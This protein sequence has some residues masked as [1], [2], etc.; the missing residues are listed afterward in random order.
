MQSVFLFFR[1]RMA[2]GRALFNAWYANPTLLR[3]TLRESQTAQALFCVP[4]GIMVSLITIFLHEAVT[5]AQYWA[6]ALT[7][8]GDLSAAKPTEMLRILGVPV[9]G[10]A[11]LGLILWGLKRW[12]SGDIVDPIEANA[13]YGGRMSVVDSLRLAL[14]AIVSNASGASVGMEAAYTQMGA[15]AT[16]RIGKMFQLRREDMRV[17][18]AAGAAAAIAT[19]FNAPLAGA[20]YGFELVLSTYT[21]AALPQV[22]VCALTGAL[23]S[24]L[25]TS[26]EQ[27]FSLPVTMTSI[28]L[29]DYPLFV[30]MGI[31]S[32][33]IGIATMKS[34]THC[35]HVIRRLKLPEW[36]RPALGGLFLGFLALAFP[37]VLG[38]GQG[39]INE[40]L[41]TH[42][43][44]LL[45]CGLL[46]AK[47]AASAICLGSGFRG[48]LFSAALFI[49]CLF[50]QICGMVAASVL[51]DANGQMEVFIL[52]GMGAVAASI[53]GAPVTMVLLVLEMTGSFPATT[54]VF[55]GVLVASII[56]RATFGY[57]FS[58]WRFHLRG[59]RIMNAHDIG[60]IRDLKVEG[61]MQTG[62]RMV[63]DTVTVAQLRSDMP[64]GSVKKV[65]VIDSFGY[66]Q[67]IIDVADLHGHD[68]D[69]DSATLSAKEVAKAQAYFLMPH[70]NIK[71]AL[72]MFAA[73]AQE[74][75]PVVVSSEDRRMLGHIAES[76]ALKRYTQEL[77]AKN[78]AQSG[79]GTPVSFS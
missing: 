29:W 19:A 71:D 15:C 47:I 60:W 64:P 61:F 51:P 12:R 1:R 27:I 35:E 38:S 52:V 72:D 14:A 53:I 48:G 56:T 63:P 79:S 22:A 7:T 33:L 26:G 6:F 55:V 77:E 11:C 40:H 73:S 34:V 49:G 62:Q 41:Q 54:A 58:T 43:P 75:L 5:L 42:W 31:Y 46:I 66:Y 65:F 18:V 44:L 36:M 2:S 30:A 4:L 45:L 10:G 13:I 23:F 17:L 76:Y 16:S 28:P 8:T 50:G 25:I 24:R 57:S 59:L 74:D 39:A 78:L 68:L 67:G 70:Q 20:F 3:R 69:Q 9:V 37:Q 32:A 21:I